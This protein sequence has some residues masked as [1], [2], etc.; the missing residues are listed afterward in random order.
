[1]SWLS[2]VLPLLVLPVRCDSLRRSRCRLGY[3]QLK[4]P[5]IVPLKH[6]SVSIQQVHARISHTYSSRFSAPA[7]ELRRGFAEKGGEEA[8]GVILDYDEEGGRD[9]MQERKTVL[10]VSPSNDIRVLS[11]SSR[12]DGTVLAL[13]P[14]AVSFASDMTLSA[15]PSTQ[16]HRCVR[17]ADCDN[18]KHPELP[19][20]WPAVA[21]TVAFEVGCG[22]RQNTDIAD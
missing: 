14:D 8:I 3:S 20:H 9:G 21:M 15:P 1:M 13:L 16:R 10:T 17:V 11:V 2:L 4:K 6:S 5:G 12:S 18:L 22:P 7:K 19:P